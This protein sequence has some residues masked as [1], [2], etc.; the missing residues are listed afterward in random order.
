M[1]PE[2]KIST[3]PQIL[4]GTPKTIELFGILLFTRHCAPISE[5]S[6]IFT[7]FDIILCGPI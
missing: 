6:P 4:P 2:D 3:V 1:T 5:W 7:P